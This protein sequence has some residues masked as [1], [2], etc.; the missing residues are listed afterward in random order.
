VVAHGVTLIPSRPTPGDGIGTV[1]VD[2]V[3]SWIG[4]YAS[5]GQ[6]LFRSGWASLPVG[7]GGM[8]VYG[9]QG[10]LMWQ[11]DR[12]RAES[13]IAVTHDDP[14]PHALFEFAPLFDPVT[15]EGDFPLGL[16]ARYNH[17]LA[18]SFIRDIRQGKESWP[19][20][21]DG[22]IVQRVLAAIRTSLDDQRWVDVLDA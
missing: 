8:R 12:R 10:T 17:R 4:V 15:D 5:G 1:D 16:L 9:S 2:D 7:G 19:S 3:A 18:E 11:Q 20:F 21:A 22:L 14:T 13:L 6:A